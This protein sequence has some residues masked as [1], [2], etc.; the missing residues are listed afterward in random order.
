MRHAEAVDLAAGDPLG[1]AERKL[2]DK[3]HRQAKRMGLMLKQLDITV[4]RVFTSPFVR[5]R[6]T[7][8][9]VTAAA[10]WYVKVRPLD[11]LK[12]N[13]QAKAMWEALRTTG[14]ESVLVVGHL[15][16]IG[17]LA[18]TLLGCEATQPLWFHKSTL[19]ALQCDALKSPNPVIRLEWMISPGM[20]KRMVGR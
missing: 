15:P 1:D 18:A 16:S 19:V 9:G 8:E 5:A 17:T 7:A 14:G 3:G 12:P 6:E 13:G 2:T 20:A 4:D 10:E 11:V